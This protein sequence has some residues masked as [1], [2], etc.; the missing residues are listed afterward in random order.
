MMKL[1]DCGKEFFG[2][3]WFQQNIRVHD[4]AMYTTVSRHDSQRSTSAHILNHKQEAEIARVFKFSKSNSKDRLSPAGP[5]FLK[6]VNTAANWKVRGQTPKTVENISFEPAKLVNPFLR[7][8][9]SQE[10]AK[11]TTLSINRTIVSQV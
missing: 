9:P 7:S 6:L 10:A 8:V 2:A 5:H 4:S 3:Y 1:H 11:P